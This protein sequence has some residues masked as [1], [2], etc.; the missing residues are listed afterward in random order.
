MA[1]ITI[2]RELG[3]EGDVIAD[4]VCQE[5]GYRR[6]DKAMLMEIAK[7][8]GVDVEAVLAKERGFAKRSTLI[9]SEMTAL[10]RRQPGVFERGGG[11]DDQT[12]ERIV[13]QAMEQFAEQGDVVIVGRGGQMVLRDW[14]MA[15]HVRLYALL[16]VRVQRVRQ[17]VN[18]SEH[19]A[20]R[21]IAESDEQKR[22][23]IRHMHTNANWKDLKHYHLIINTAHVSPEVAAQIIVLA[24]KHKDK[25]QPD[26]SFGT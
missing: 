8:A 24:A 7:E 4:L 16:D 10:R 19:E 13:R 25:V 26:R 15:L 5:L 2:S 9:S 18:I 22:Q 23:Y 17:R 11:L 21:R 1:V 3:S 14:P 20:K 6:V 12:Y